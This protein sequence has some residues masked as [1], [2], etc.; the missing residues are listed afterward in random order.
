MEPADKDRFSQL[1]SWSASQRAFTH[2]QVE[3][4]CDDKTKFSL[5][6]REGTTFDGGSKAPIQAGEAVVSC[7]AAMTLS[8][9]NAL[10][11]GPLRA[12]WWEEP[13]SP[14]F[15]G[16][17]MENTPPHVIGRFFLVQQ[18]L[19]G[20]GSHWSAYIDTLPQPEHLSSWALPPFWP[21]EDAEWLRGTNA[22]VALEE[23]RDNVAGE[24]KRA[25]KILKEEGY[26][27]WQSYSR[28]LYHWA[29]CI[30]TS[31]SFR[32][33]LVVP[34]ETVHKITVRLPE[35]CTM[36]DF[37]ILLP[38]FDIAN[39]SPTALVAW[40]FAA[41][42]NAVQFRVQDSYRPGQQ[43]FNNYGMKTNSELLL[44][45]G[46]ILPETETFHNDYVHLRKREE[47]GE[48]G[49]EAV[50][51]D[52]TGAKPR[53]FLISLRPLSDASS[54]VGHRRQF[55]SG[56]RD[57][58]LLPAFDLFEDS[59]LWDLYLALSTSAEKQAMELDKA[60]SSGAGGNGRR[61]A[62]LD[63]IL[64]P[65]A[66][67]ELSD[68]ALRVQ[69]TLFSKLASD[70]SRLVE[71]APQ[72]VNDTSTLRPNQRLALEYRRQYGKV[73]HTAIRA[74]DPDAELEDWL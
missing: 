68:L 36:D 73:L 62:I 8:Y 61:R 57:S 40:D 26:P 67:S 74:L 16:R 50:G 71:C 47:A 6:V 53:D 17:F 33:S 64:A 38:L 31:R 20:R 42:L 46:F 34:G 10:V 32:P 14:A 27:G 45:Y 29:F 55:S 23:I 63:E 28:L 51:S 66:R 58:R 48:R 69:G 56:N 60:P 54:V 30:F 59:L 52:T 37:S 4:F 25:R 7:S 24:F 35:G 9:L 21:Q 18:Y 49:E 41:D 1:V 22:H 43:I 44:G 3:V 39:H 13:G 15:P 2:P 19:L 70:Y 5:R 65:D 12:L 72:S 11:G